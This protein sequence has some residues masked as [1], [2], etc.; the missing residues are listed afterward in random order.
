VPTTQEIRTELDA[1]PLALGYATLRTRSDAPSALAARLN[2]VG[3]S[4][5]TLTRT[6]VDTADV[7]AAVVGT[8]ILALTQANRDLLAILTSTA[9][10]RTGAAAM[11]NSLGAIFA[12]NTVSRANLIALSTRPASRGEALW[13][14]GVNVSATQVADALALS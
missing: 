12:A 2:E 9:R 8:E 5:Q 11:R 13:G 7:L 6:W 4:S 1:D 14:E 10:V 3:A